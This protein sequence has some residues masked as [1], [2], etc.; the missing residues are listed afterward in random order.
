MT[1]QVTAMSF[2]GD[3]G[4][5]GY[6]PTERS[7]MSLPE[8]A[9]RD[10]WLRARLELLQREKE[11]TRARD[12]LNAD[13]RRLPMVRIEKDYVFEGPQGT[14]GLADLFE[15]RRQLFL[16]H[17]MF[18]PAW[19]DGCAS[20]SAGADELAQGLIDHLHIRDTTFAAVSRAPLSKLED[21]KARK[22]WSFPWYSSHGSDFNYDFHATIDESVTPLEINY[23]SRAELEAAGERMRWMVTAEQP[24]EMPGFSCFLRD[25]DDVFHTYSVFARGTEDLGG[26]YAFL[27]LTA[28]GRQED[29]EEP[30]G[31]ADRERDATPSF[32]S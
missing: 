24:F 20:C 5:H 12:A 15:G 8:I 1:S 29:W 7:K 23:R 14:A 21:Y 18:D 2:G 9:T 16:Q 4:L 19:T 30:K 27:D 6:L 10:E 26:A 3:A 17:F 22:G 32:R 31:R 28:L 13:R 25:G 11:L